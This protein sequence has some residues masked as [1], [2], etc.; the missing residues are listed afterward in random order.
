M[1]GRVLA[2]DV[3]EAR[4]GLALS[5][6][7]GMLASPAGVI[8]RRQGGGLQSLVQRIRQSEAR[9][10]VFG[11]PLD[12][13][14]QEGP[15]ARL[16]RAFIAKLQQALAEAQ[17]PLPLHPYDERLTTR[18]AQQGRLAGGMSKKK[19]R[20]TTDDAEAAAVL[21]Q[22]WLDRERHRLASA[23]ATPTDPS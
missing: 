16:V 3:G 21:L 1:T 6:P 20:T 7:L 2:M 9:A 23:Q 19:R 15:Q 11:L 5:D 14:G 17:L 12:L 22:G 10:I 8:D 18:L 4:V 13:N